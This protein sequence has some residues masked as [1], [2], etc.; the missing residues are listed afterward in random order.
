VAEQTQLE[1]A[2]RILQRLSVCSHVTVNELYDLFDRKEAKRTL[3]RTL[4]SIERT[5]V[6]LLI[7]HG[8]H[9]EPLYSL[10]GGFDFI[11][12]R[13][14]PEEGIAASL[15]NQFKSIFA[16][17][18]IGKTLHAYRCVYRTHCMGVEV[19]GASGGFG[20][21]IIEIQNERRTDQDQPLV[22]IIHNNQHGAINGKVSLRTSKKIRFRHPLKLGY[23]EP[24]KR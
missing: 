16:G 7:E 23:L 12:L 10:R 4:E 21:D 14:T 13:L 20:S 11:P 19:G 24:S 5:N 18:S 15:L 2:I 1:R 22:P 9:N 8:A 6:P 3:Q 17:T